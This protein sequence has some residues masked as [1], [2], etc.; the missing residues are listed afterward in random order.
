ML[1]LSYRF[2]CSSKTFRLKIVIFKSIFL[3]AVYIFLIGS[4]RKI[5]ISLTNYLVI[6]L[7]RSLVKT[8]TTREINNI[9]F[10]N[11]ETAQRYY[12]PITLLLSVFQQTYSDPKY[13]IDSTLKL[14]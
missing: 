10:G 1:F 7:T 11:A 14:T 13:L 2:I 5:T 3:I 12:L 4:I 9:I 6:F 8:L